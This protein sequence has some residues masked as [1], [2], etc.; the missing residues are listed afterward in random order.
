DEQNDNLTN[1]EMPGRLA[2]V[3]PLSEIN[4]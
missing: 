4:F 2:T 1:Y 3:Q